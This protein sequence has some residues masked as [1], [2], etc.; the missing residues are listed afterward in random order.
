MNLISSYP[1][2]PNDFMNGNTGIV[3]TGVSALVAAFLTLRRFLSSDRAERRKE[4]ADV[5]SIDRIMRLLEIE[6]RRAD[7]AEARADQF[8]RE[9]NEAVQMI[10]ALRG[11]VA[12][13]SQR[14]SDLQESLL[15][16]KRPE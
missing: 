8:A 1:M 11:E 5:N 4:T 15:K 2:A 13:L 6:R 14:V 7:N 16:Y 3:A 9:R 10:G 12:A